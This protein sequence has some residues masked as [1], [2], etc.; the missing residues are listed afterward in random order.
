[1]TQ[2]DILELPK[3]SRSGVAVQIFRNKLTP[4]EADFKRKEEKIQKK[5][6]QLREKAGNIC[7][8]KSAQFKT[9]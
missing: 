7:E 4:T 6:Q 3:L 5:V 2:K 1:M 9:L 8:R